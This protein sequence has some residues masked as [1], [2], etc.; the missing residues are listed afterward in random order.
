MIDS[1]H[2]LY[3]ITYDNKYNK[4]LEY[5]YCCNASTNMAIMLIKWYCLL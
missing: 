1:A 4:I 2:T 3:Q 5:V